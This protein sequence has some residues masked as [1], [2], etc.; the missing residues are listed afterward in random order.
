MAGRG[1]RGSAEGWLEGAV[2]NHP[3]EH[4]RP[5]KQ[6]SHLKLPP[7]GLCGQRGLKCIVASYVA[8]PDV[9]SHSP[10]AS[11]SDGCPVSVST[12]KVPRSPWLMCVKVSGAPGPALP[13][14]HLILNPCSGIFCQRLLLTHHIHVP[15]SR[16]EDRKG[17]PVLRN[18]GTTKRW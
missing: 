6:T 7:V 18:A 5:G 14:S 12:S 3:T 4:L 16:I 13:F 2:R 9:Q 1:G 10:C 17:L 8:A 15:G 11:Y